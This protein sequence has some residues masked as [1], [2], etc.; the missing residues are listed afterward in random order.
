MRIHRRLID[1]ILS[2]FIRLR[3]FRCTHVKCHWEGNLR[4]RE[5]LIVAVPTIVGNVNRCWTELTLL[6]KC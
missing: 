4:E 3:R 6:F 1:R 2:V 5:R